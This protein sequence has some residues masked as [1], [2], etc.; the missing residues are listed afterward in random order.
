M[1]LKAQIEGKGGEYSTNFQLI[2]F[3]HKNWAT[4]NDCPTIITP[5]EINEYLE[6]KMM[7]DDMAELDR[8][9]QLWIDSISH[10]YI[11]K[12]MEKVTAAIEKWTS[13]NLSE[14]PSDKS[15]FHEKNIIATPLPTSS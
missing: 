15:E 13:E 1:Q 4:I 12:K 14:L 10:K 9:G 5:A 11:K 6:A 7:E 2:L 8:I 3:G